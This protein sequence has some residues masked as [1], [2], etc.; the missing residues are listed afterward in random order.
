MYCDAGV[1]AQLG[2]AVVAVLASSLVARRLGLS[3]TAQTAPPSTAR[4]WWT[5]AIFLG[6]LGA[7]NRVLFCDGLFLQL[8]VVALVAG[9]GVWLGSRLQDRRR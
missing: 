5:L 7:A 9:G 3:M 1:L 8:A 2:V 6:P 4:F